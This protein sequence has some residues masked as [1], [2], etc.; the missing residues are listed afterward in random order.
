[1]VRP[2]LRSFVISIA[3]G[4]A[5]GQT[6]LSRSGLVLEYDRAIY[7]LQRGIALHWVAPDLYLQAFDHMSRSGTADEQ[8]TQEYEFV[9]RQLA[10]ELSSEPQSPAIW[11]E[12]PPA[13]VRAAQQ[14]DTALN[15]LDFARR[16]LL[17][18]TE[19]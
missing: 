7:A 3:S 17:G 2:R 8:L 18:S 19:R 1:M 12:K 16:L 4:V 15:H 14:A 13:S 5:V 10:S 6:G 9:R 11:D